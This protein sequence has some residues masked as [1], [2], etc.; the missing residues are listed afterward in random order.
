MARPKITIVGAGA[1]GTAAAQ[2]IAAKELGDLVLF[3]IVDGLAAGKAL[4][5][6]QAGPV[7]DFDGRITGTQDW[8]D[9]AGSALV[10]VTSGSPR[11]PGMTRDDLLNVNFDIVRGVVEAAL[12]RSPGAYLIILTNP[13]DVLTYAAWRVSGLPRARVMGQSGILDTARFRT[14]LAWEL[15]VSV[16]DVTALVLGGHGD[17]MVPLVRYSAA[18][19]IPVERLLPAETLARLVERTRAGGAEVVNLLKTGSAF[20]APGAALAQMAEAILRDKKRILPVA[21]VLDGEYGE[22]DVVMGVPVRL[23]AGGVEHVY[24][25]E[26]TEEER[27]A[28]RRS[29]QAVREPIGVIAARL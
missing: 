4:D 9:T 13:V 10:I 24:E 2:W 21:A 16:E 22:R 8:A 29:A 1:T 19:G 20:L 17:T 3:D 15:G 6:A 23:G 14:F 18:G 7:E 27:A 25:L 12:E 5:L 28:F 11:K 26:L